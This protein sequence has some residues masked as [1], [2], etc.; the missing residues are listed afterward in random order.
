MGRDVVT[1]TQTLHIPSVPWQVLII[2]LWAQDEEQI[3]GADGP[4][5]WLPHHYAQ[6]RRS[7]SP[8][9]ALAEQVVIKVIPAAARPVAKHWWQSRFF[10]WVRLR[11]K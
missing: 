11:G 9:Q 5:S 7:P 6:P 3:D 1:P 8:D 4:K 2:E 10:V